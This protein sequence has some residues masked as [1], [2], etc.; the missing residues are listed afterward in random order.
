MARKAVRAHGGDIVARYLPGRGCVFSVDLPLASEGEPDLTALAHSGWRSF[1]A[2]RRLVSHLRL[3]W[4]THVLLPDRALTD[5]DLVSYSALF[6][7]CTLERRVYT[8]RCRLLHSTAMAVIVRCSVIPLILTFCR[9]V[10]LVVLVVRFGGRPVRRRTS[11]T[12]R[13]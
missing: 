2:A 3:G 6:W 7:R 5:C 1:G 11:R 13:G 4:H 9:F 10:V 8:V 12:K